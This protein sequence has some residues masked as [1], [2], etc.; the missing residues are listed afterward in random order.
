MANTYLE[1]AF[2]VPVTPE[3]AALL[4]ECF[5]T[6]AEISA[7]FASIPQEELE[8][9]LRWGSSARFVAYLRSLTP[10]PNPGFLQY[11]AGD[12]TCVS[13]I[14]RRSPT[15]CSAMPKPLPAAIMRS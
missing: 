5:A 1:T 9:D 11:P 7:G 15:S 13:A 12:P 8:L 3:E 10:S 6:T 14:F 2:N 4:E